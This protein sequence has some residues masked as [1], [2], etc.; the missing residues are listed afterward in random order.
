MK[1]NP[2]NN[3]QTNFNGKFKNN[4]L[5]NKSLE[6]ASDY[7]L[8]KFGSLLRRMKAQNDNFVFSI[9][10]SKYDLNAYYKNLEIELLSSGDQK[11]TVFPVSKQTKRH[12]DE[13]TDNVFNDVIKKINKKLEEIYPEQEITKAK[14]E[15][16]LAKIYKNLD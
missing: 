16:S 9:D 7:D 10:S 1:I 14:R 3:N 12:E 15:N 5:L 2:I 4:E 8:K 11:L 6:K 13:F